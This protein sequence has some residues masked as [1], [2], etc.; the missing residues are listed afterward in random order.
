M[1]GSA[2]AEPRSPILAGRAFDAHDGEA[3]PPVVVVNQR[4]VKEF[5]PNENPVGKTLRNGETLFEV[6]SDWIGRVLRRPA[7][8]PAPAVA[9]EVIFGETSSMLLQSQR[10]IPKVALDGGYRFR[11]PDLEPALRDLL[12]R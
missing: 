4:F 5:F 1:C 10:V 2:T 3:S 8:L 7:F 9:L 12:G 11:H 6:E